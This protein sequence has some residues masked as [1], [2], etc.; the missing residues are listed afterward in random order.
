MGFRCKAV[1]RE[2]LALLLL[3][4]GSIVI[5]VGFFLTFSWMEALEQGSHFVEAGSLFE[6]SW[7][8][9]KGDRTEGGFT[10][11]GGNGQADLTIVSPSEVNIYYWFAEGR[12]DNGFTAQETGVYRMIFRNRDGVNDQIIDVH[13]RSPYEPR[14]TIYDAIGLSTM[15]AGALIVF[16]GIRG[17]RHSKPPMRP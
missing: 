5:V 11:S 6:L 13:F 3:T 12:Y 14:L 7:Y 10:V 17:F 8:L 1:K 15:L 4:A 2:S 16:L 9:E